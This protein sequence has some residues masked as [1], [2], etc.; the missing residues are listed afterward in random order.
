MKYRFVAGLTVL[1]VAATS[2]HSLVAQERSASRAP[3]NPPRT[4]PSGAGVIVGRVFDAS[5]NAPIRRAQIQASN[6][7][8]FVDALSDD[9]GRFQLGNLTPGR[10][11]VTVSKGGYFSWHIGQKRPFEAPPRISITRGQRLNADVPLSRGGVISGRVFDETGEPLAALRVRVYRARMSQGYRRLEAVAAADDTDDTG[12]FRI[13]GLPPGDYYVAASLR[14]APADSVVQTT[15]SPTYY[16]GT[17]D[18]AD[19][20]RVRVGLGTEA[21]AIFPLLPIRHVRVTGTVITASGT[22]ANA[23]LNLVSEAAELGMPLGIGGVTREDGTFTLPD[24]PPGRYTLNASLR[25]D[26][27]SENGSTPMTIGNDDVTGITLVTGRA[28][29]MK[30]QFVADAGV[31]RQIPAGLEVIAVAAR[32]GGSVISSDMGTSFELGELAEPFTLRVDRLPEGWAVKAI[33]VNGIDVTDTKAVLA[34][35]QEADARIVITDRVTQ[36]SGTV[37]TGGRPVKGDVLVFPED[38]SK[39]TYP[40]RY[41]RTTS[42]DDRGRFRISGLP[43]GERYLAIAADYVEEGEHYDPEFLNRMRDAAVVFS[44]DEAETRA[45]DLTLL[46]R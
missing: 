32:A 21:T 36:I 10:W 35:N 46:E 13:Y 26:G 3:A 4:A 2:G 5:T 20:Q 19:A 44:L 42:A 38:P 43:G 40:S 15:Y 9:D 39:W 18:L 22:P 17:G 25:G 37:T 8:T 16:P 28:A 45:L 34:S 12:A 23:F 11:S 1:L 29:T 27:P 31:S 41:V 30:G 33:V 14:M 7:R 6:D 24:I